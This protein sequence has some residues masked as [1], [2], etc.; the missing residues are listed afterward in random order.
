[1]KNKELIRPEYYHIPLIVGEQ[2]QPHEA[3]VWAVVYW[4]ERMKDGR[5]IASNQRIAEALPYASSAISVANALLVL[6]EKGLVQRVFKDDK[7][8]VRSEIK[9]TVCTVRVSPTGDTGITHRLNR[10]SPTGE[11][12][13]NTN[14]LKEQLTSEAVASPV[15]VTQKRSDSK[16]TA[17]GYNPL[18]AEIVHAFEE[19]NPG[20]KAWY[21]NKTQRQACD[22]LINA[23]GLEKVKQVIAILPQ[24]NLTRFMPCIT[25]PMQLRDKWSQLENAVKRKKSEM[26]SSQSNIAF[27]SRSTLV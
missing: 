27:T 1:M 12:I 15:K 22:D 6:E 19:L 24:T 23:H 5:C 10:V 17:G 18:G 9:V 2:V 13:S 14:I 11:Q 8:R 7:K 3:F 26:I 4:F 20:A 16:R 25:T 21:G